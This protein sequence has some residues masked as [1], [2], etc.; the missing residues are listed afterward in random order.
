MA[1]KGTALVSGGT[2]GI[3]AAVCRQLASEGYDIAVVD[4]AEGEKSAELVRDLTERFGVHAV[5]LKADLT[6]YADCAAAAERA[7][8]EPG[9]ITVLI[10]CAGITHGSLFLGEETPEWMDRVIQVN[11]MSQLYLTHAVLP[12]MIKAGPG[13]KNI[14]NFSSSAALMGMSP[15]ITY[16]ASK[17][18]IIGMT[19]AMANEFTQYGIRVNAV[20]PGSTKT[21]MMEEPAGKM[22]LSVDE[23]A[24]MVAK[25]SP[26]GMICE[27]EDM[28]QAVSYLIN[29]R[30]MTGMTLAPNAGLTL[31]SF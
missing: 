15:C 4:I 31:Y 14:V 1:K 18:G 12:Y 20:A 6:R 3:G 7:A 10:N 22:G 24:D 13:N 21:A 23:V 30:V 19:K 2:G 16:C 25:S 29:A 17:M 26:L 5:F 27:P 11:L 28:A 8:S 9:D